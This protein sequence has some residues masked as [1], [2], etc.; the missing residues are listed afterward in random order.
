M[1]EAPSEEELRAAHWSWGR[2]VVVHPA[3]NSDFADACVRYREFLA[4][5]S[6]FSPPRGSKSSSTPF[7]RR[8]R[9]RS[10]SDTSSDSDPRTG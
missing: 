1:S 8:P 5:E 2:Y 4:D 6:T 7:A 9:R 3:G 10:A